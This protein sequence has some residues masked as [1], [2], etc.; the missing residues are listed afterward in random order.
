MIFLD[1]SVL[2]LEGVKGNPEFIFV[3]DFSIV[4]IEVTVFLRTST[5]NFPRLV[6]LEMSQIDT[7]FAIYSVCQLVQVHTP[8]DRLKDKT[9]IVS[10]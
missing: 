6:L 2:S 5:R 4:E 7:L 10:F 9:E 1:L 3:T 8:G